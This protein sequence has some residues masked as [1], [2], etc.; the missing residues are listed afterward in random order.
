MAAN[1]CVNCKSCNNPNALEYG[2]CFKPEHN[3]ACD[4]G[5]GGGDSDSSEEDDC[6]VIRRR[7][8]RMDFAD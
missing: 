7:L 5:F 3:S 8:T 1:D 2:K 6:T 4:C